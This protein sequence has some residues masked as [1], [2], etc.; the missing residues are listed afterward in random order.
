MLSILPFKVDFWLDRPEFSKNGGRTN[1]YWTL[2]TCQFLDWLDRYLTHVFI[3]SSQDSQVELWLYLAISYKVTIKW[4]SFFW[5]IKKKFFFKLIIAAHRLSLVAVSGSCSPV[6]VCGLL[7]VAPGTEHR[8][9]VYRLQ[10]GRVAPGARP[11][12]RW[13]PGKWLGLFFS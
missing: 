12:W 10:L 4:L 5:S 8:L 1:V 11:R 6:V 13:R 3:S 9:W 2:V 7:E